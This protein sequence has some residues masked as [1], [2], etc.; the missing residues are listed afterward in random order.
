[1]ND[2]D[3][4]GKKC[5][6]FREEAVLEAKQPSQGVQFLLNPFIAGTH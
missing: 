1:M 4:Y 2:I 5:I 6:V 3:I